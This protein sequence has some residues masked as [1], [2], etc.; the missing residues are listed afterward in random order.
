MQYFLDTEFDERVDEQGRGI[1]WLISIGLVADDGRRFYAECEGFDWS[2]ADPWLVENVKPHLS[3]VTESRDSIRDRLIGFVGDDTSP[4][5]W[6]YVGAYD[7]VAMMQLFGKMLHKPK[8]W[9]NR[10][11]ELKDFIEQTG[12]SKKDLPVQDGAV[13]K[14]VDDAEWNRKAYN[15]VTGQR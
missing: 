13:H 5:F 11:R 3:G 15:F 12:L 4:E 7:W 2:T 9:P 14:A 1:I 8:T 10:H 6:A